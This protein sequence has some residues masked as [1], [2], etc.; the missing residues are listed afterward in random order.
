[1]QTRAHIMDA[2][3]NQWSNTTNRSLEVSSSGLASER[4]TFRQIDSETLRVLH[5]SVLGGFR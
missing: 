4:E 5:E 1:M 2:F 3:E